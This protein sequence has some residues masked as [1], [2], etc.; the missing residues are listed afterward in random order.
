MD[1]F[2]PHLPDAETRGSDLLDL[3]LESPLLARLIQEVRGT[4]FEVTR[5]Y[6]RTYNRHNR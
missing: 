2:K 1:H 5:A 6:N 4:D 3:P